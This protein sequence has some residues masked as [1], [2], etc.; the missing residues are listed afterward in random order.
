MIANVTAAS[1]SVTVRLA[2]LLPATKVGVGPLATLGLLRVS[3]SVS[4]PRLNPPL[5]IERRSD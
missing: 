2:A 4:P 1:I 5:V 3:D